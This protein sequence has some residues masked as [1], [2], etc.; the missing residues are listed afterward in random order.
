MFENFLLHVWLG[1]IKSWKVL[2]KIINI[3]INV[4]H[5]KVDVTDGSMV[6]HI[7]IIGSDVS[8]FLI[9]CYSG[10][11]IRERHCC[12]L[13]KTYTASSSTCHQDSVALDAGLLSV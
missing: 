10:R 4:I 7:S 5:C 8:D 9:S 6:K 1:R 11:P 3:C 2:H 13:D 12:T